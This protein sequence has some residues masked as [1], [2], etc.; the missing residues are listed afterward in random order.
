MY[1][2]DICAGEDETNGRLSYDRKA[3][4][5]D[6]ETLLTIARIYRIHAR[7]YNHIKRSLLRGNRQ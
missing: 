6:E 3:C 5:V 1:H 2:C 4:K 7:R